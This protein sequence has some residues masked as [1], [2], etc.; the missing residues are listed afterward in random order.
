MT[1]TKLL[2]RLLRMKGFKVTWFAVLENLGILHLGVKPHKTG[3]R[4]P[5]CGRRGEIVARVE[6]RQWDDLVVCGLRS[7]F[8]THPA[9]Y[10]ARRMAASKN[11]YPGQKIMHA[12]PIG[13]NT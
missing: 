3:C 9:R 2:S 11:K 5:H 1:S 6:C 7:I 4:C 8:F 12:L 10:T 13:W